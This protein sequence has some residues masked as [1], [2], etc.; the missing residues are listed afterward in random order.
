MRSIFF[1]VISFVLLFS[2]QKS[3]SPASVHPSLKIEKRSENKN[4]QDND[5][6]VYK[7]ASVESRPDFP[8]GM[9]KFHVFLK[10]NY[11]VPQALMTDDASRGGVFASFIVE[12]DGTLSEI[13][14]IRDFGY[15][16]GPEL[17]R[18]L[19]LSPNWIP[20]IKDGKPVRYLYS[21]AYYV[22]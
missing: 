10:K 21:I 7:A 22:Q 6:E 9:G 11:V 16:T 18:V 2:C 1:T 4:L 13:K 17:E 20:A 3:T 12:K 19:K 15:G 5:N 14:I 8:G